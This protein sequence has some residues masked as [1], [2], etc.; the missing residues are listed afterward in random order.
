MDK[1]LP[2]IITWRKDKIGF[3]PPQ[4]AWMQD[5]RLQEM[6]H[7]AKR[8]LVQEKILRGNV[9]AKQVEA[10]GAHQANAF[11][12]RYLSAATIL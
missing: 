8:K 3:E 6:I 4:Q 1:K 10:T 2:D 12:W 11:D 5:L 7:E 9:L